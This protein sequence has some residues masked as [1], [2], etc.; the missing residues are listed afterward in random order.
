MKFVR[1]SFLSMLMSLLLVGTVSAQGGVARSGTEDARILAI[2][3]SLMAWNGIGGRSIP[4]VLSLLLKEPVRSHANVGA[5]MIYA[6]P[7]TGAMG[8]RISS[9][10]HKGS[11]DWVVV[12]GGGNDLWLGCG[13][14]KCSARM[15]KMV[16]ADGSRGEVPDLMRKIR[17]TGARVVF[18]GYLRSPGTGSTIE[19]CKDEGDAYDARIAVMAKQMQG[20]WFVSNADLVPAGD[21]SYHSKDRIHPSRKGSIAIAQRVAAL[22][23]KHDETR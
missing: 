3:D 14:R 15:D 11:Y 5:F 10:F 23:R 13:C 8:K 2:G 7:I 22:I 17:K 21:T 16:S 20:V 9:Q 6:L 19:H 18:I 4:Q 1:I 12:N